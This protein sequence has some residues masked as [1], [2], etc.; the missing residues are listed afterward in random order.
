V[1]GIAAAGL[2]IRGSFTLPGYRRLDSTSR[3]DVTRMSLPSLE[4][5]PQLSTVATL[6]STPLEVTQKA[7][8]GRIFGLHGLDRSRVAGR[9]A[10][11]RSSR[12]RLLHLHSKCT[13]PRVLC[14]LTDGAHAAGTYLSYHPGQSL[15]R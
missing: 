15:V 8:N 2:A 5:A 14:S 9:L 6:S 1:H 11:Q 13:D 4:H 7:L 3:A 12:A 10:G